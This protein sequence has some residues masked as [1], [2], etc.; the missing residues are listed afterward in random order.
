MFFFSINIDFICLNANIHIV[1]VLKL[2]YILKLVCMNGES[3][4]YVQTSPETSKHL[5]RGEIP[6]FITITTIYNTHQ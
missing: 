5:E 4:E 2:L 6:S 3:I 1:C